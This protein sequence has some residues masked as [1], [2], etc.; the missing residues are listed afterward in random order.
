MSI[1]ESTLTAAQKRARDEAHAAIDNCFA[2]MIGDTKQHEHAL[3]G[4][5]EQVR[6]LEAAWDA[7]PEDI[8]NVATDMKGAVWMLMN[9]RDEARTQLAK[10]RDAL[11]D[12]LGRHG[13]GRGELFAGLQQLSEDCARFKR[14]RDEAVEV[15]RR[16][17][18]HILV[19]ELAED[20]GVSGD[21]PANHMRVAQLRRRI[22]DDGFIPDW[23]RPT[24]GPSSPAGARAPLDNPTPAASATTDASACSAEMRATLVKQMVSTP[25]RDVRTYRLTPP[26]ETSEGPTEYVVSSGCVAL[27][28]PETYLFRANADGEVAS[29]VELNGSFRGAIDH[30][31]ALRNAGYSVDDEAPR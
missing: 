19:A 28:V 30:G 25:T 9:A 16:I 22:D 1:T 24:P 11:H 29:W 3:D 14:E 26:M 12:V 17:C 15:V 4:M 5:R 21:C 7:L 18:E 23:M 27:G 20:G 31:Q 8:R 13:I 2:Q 6:E 10:L